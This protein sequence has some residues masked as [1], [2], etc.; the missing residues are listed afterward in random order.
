MGFL[1]R[2]NQ[3]AGSVVSPVFSDPRLKRSDR[4]LE[5]GE[6][7]TG[8]I[9]GI[10][11][12]LEDSTTVEYLA[13]E[14]VTLS[15]PLRAGVSVRTDRMERL[16]L[17]M[18]V[19]LRVDVDKG[20]AVLDWPAMLASWGFGEGSEAQ[21]IVR[22]VPEDGVRER[23]LDLRVEKRLKKG[24]AARAVVVEM[25]QRSAFGMPT[26]N[27]VVVLELADGRRVQTAGDEVP[28][29]CKWLVAPGAEL[30]VALDPSKAEQ[31]TID[32]AATATEAAAAGVGAAMGDAP[33]A[34]SIAELIEQRRAAK[35][36]EAMSGAGAAPVVE[37]AAAGDGPDLSP[38]E[39]V[40]LETWAAVEIG[41]GRD[42]VPPAGYDEYAQGYGV[43]AGAWTRVDAAWRARMSGGDWRVGAAMG[44]ALETARKRKRRPDAR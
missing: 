22:S 44:D 30:P 18:A 19:L 16:R 33:P 11:R 5:E 37:S 14:A 12:K 9:A 3:A 39:G 13:L 35:S 21:R 7:M 42:R 27:W 29:Y 1:D 8:R 2:L 32:W 36:A 24:T 10:E 31:A 38:I 17:G 40:S 6:Q 34:G 25:R 23:A 20:R 26:E 43:Q 15:G 28:F 4:L 41:T